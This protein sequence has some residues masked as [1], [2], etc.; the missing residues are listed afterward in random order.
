MSVSHVPVGHTVMVQQ[1][2]KPIVMLEIIVKMGQIIMV[3]Q[4]V[5]S[6]MNVQTGS[7]IHV[8]QELIKMNQI[9]PHVNNV[10]AEFIVKPQVVHHP[11]VINVLMDTF[12]KRAQKEN[13]Q[14]RTPREM[15]TMARALLVTFVKAASKQNVTLENIKT[16]LIKVHVKIVLLVSFVMEPVLKHSIAVNVLQVV[17]VLKVQQAKRHVPRELT[18]VKL[19][20]EAV[21]TVS[22]VRVVTFVMHVLLLL[23][24]LTYVPSVITASSEPNHPMGTPLLQLH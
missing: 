3:L 24:T 23:M 11:Q 15:A 8:H 21:L 10:H 20:R 18:E 6:V 17:S 9:K 16:K 5:Q 2:K 19:E 14:P 7:R 13:I 22:H 1:V 12:V 4:V